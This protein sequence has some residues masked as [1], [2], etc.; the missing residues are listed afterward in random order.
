VRIK[1]ASRAVG[2]S[3][4]AETHQVVFEDGDAV[5]A[6]SVIIATG[7]R[8]NR[9][10]LDRLAELEGVG[11]YYAA[12]QMEAQACA[13]KPAAVVGGGNSAGQAAL[14]LSRT[15]REVHILIRGD[16]LASSMS[17]YLIDQ[18]DRHPLIHVSPRSVV[19]GLIGDSVLE[20]V[21]VRQTEAQ[22]TRNLAISGLFVF[23]GAT[24]S[25]RWLEGQLAEDDHGFLMTGKDV[26]VDSLSDRSFAPLLL[27]TSR[28]RIFC[29]GDVRSGSVKRVA[30]AIGEGSMAVRLVFDRLQASTLAVVA[31]PN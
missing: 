29:V 5:T 22:E 25:T 9:L 14:F 7:A 24:P 30:T 6:K 28:P 2:L 21:E 1:L 31:P 11:V 26:P 13:G 20:G 19:S 16:S 17:H 3:S 18:I 15:C 10:P 8:Y 12:S 27:E 23:I 4:N